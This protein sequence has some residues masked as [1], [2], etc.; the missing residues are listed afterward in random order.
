MNSRIKRMDLRLLVAFVVAIPCAFGGAAVAGHFHAPVWLVY[1]SAAV[2][3]VPG[4]LL[5]VRAL[6]TSMD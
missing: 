5:M 3:I 1:F 2:A 4:A 6:A